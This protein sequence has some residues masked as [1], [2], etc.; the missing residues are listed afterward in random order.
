MSIAICVIGFF[1]LMR[2]KI[3]KLTLQAAKGKRPDRD[4]MLQP[5]F[6]AHYKALNNLSSDEETG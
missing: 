1:G 4:N 5:G 3:R 2:R 6:E